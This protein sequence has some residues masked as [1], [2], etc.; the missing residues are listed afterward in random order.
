[1]AQELDAGHVGIIGV[2]HVGMASAAALFHASLVSRLTLV[3]LDGRRAEG[4]AAGKVVLQVTAA[5]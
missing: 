4:E 5:T 1:M 2:G 3:D